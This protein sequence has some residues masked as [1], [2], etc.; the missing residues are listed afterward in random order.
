ME[1]V[2]ALGLVGFGFRG[3]EAAILR[4]DIALDHDFGIGDRPGVDR[5]RLDHP[6]REP[7]RRA[8]DARARRSR[9]AG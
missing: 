7:L 3:L 9:T 4:V 6:H 5:A 1:V 8:G 2:A